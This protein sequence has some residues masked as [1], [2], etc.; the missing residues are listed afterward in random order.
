MGVRP[1]F[2][3]DDHF[4]DANIE[5]PGSEPFRCEAIDCRDQRGEEPVAID[6]ELRMK[7][8]EVEGFL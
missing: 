5:I 6:G 8:G 4:P 1:F 2:Q 7:V 3:D